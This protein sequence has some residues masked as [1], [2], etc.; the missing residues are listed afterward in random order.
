MRKFLY[1]LI[2]LL[3]VLCQSCVKET[4]D[5]FSGIDGVS[6]SP[7]VM[8]PVADAHL[9]IK[10]IYNNYSEGAT[11]EEGADKKLQFVYKGTDSLPPRQF[12]GMPPIGIDYMLALDQGAINQFNT[13][14]F[15]SNAFSNY[16]LVKTSN[17]ERLKK[18]FVNKG[19][20]VVEITSQLKHD[21]DIVVTYPSITKNGV[22]ISDTVHFKYTGT[23]PLRVNKTIR[24]DGYTMDLSDNGISFNVIPYLFEISLTRIPGN[25]ISTSDRVTINEQ[26]NVQSYSYIQGYMGKFTILTFDETEDLDIFDRQIDGNVFVKD[27][28]LRIR[29]ENG[30]GM[31]VLARVSNMYIT[32]GKGAVLPITI[33]QFKDTF[34]LQYPVEGGP[35]VVITE[36]LIDKTNSNIDQV[37]SAAPQ[38]VSYRIEFIANNDETLE[39]NRL[40]DTSSFKIRAHFEIPLEL[41]IF[42]YVLESSGKN[43]L[44]KQD[45][46]FTVEWAKF[47]MEA[48][49]RFPSS[50]NLQVYFYNVGTVN[51]V[52]DTTVV[53]DSLFSE[54]FFVP[55]AVVDANGE[56]VQPQAALREVFV[57]KDKYEK[58]L[59]GS[60]YKIQARLRSSEFNGN[61]PYV[62]IYSD[63]NVYVKL[64][65]ETKATYIVE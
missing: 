35:P 24:M 15:F 58:L 65:V 32:T 33:N 14:G 49:N 6:G 1:L 64:G 29:L 20:F 39:D 30:I 19:T 63:Q 3:G 16:A 53:V 37:F 10:E 62:T 61:L 13:L 60:R 21:A 28:K 50:L 38:K 51:G 55:P 12:I 54:D 22:P 25:S 18:I 8:L 11:I 2:S 4:I 17:K 57:P 5:K 9:G 7:E 26:V 41:K 42:R 52:Q 27:P 48:L 23:L 46:N 45:P 36:Y 56:V 59:T 34:S 31:P 43:S 40:Y 47:R 44:P